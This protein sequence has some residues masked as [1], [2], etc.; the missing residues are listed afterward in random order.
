M[1]KY[2][3]YAHYVD[4]KPVY[5]GKGSGRRYKMPRE[6]NDHTSVILYNNIDEYTALELEK[7]LI[8]LIGLDNLRNKYNFNAPS[9]LRDIYGKPTNSNVIEMFNRATDGDMEAILFIKSKI[10]KIYKSVVNKQQLNTGN[11]KWK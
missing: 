6:Y 1:D 10:P 4:N 5:I 7:W 2:Y 8:N 3:V 11:N 9:G